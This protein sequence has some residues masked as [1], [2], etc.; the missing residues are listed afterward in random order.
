MSFLTCRVTST[1]NSDHFLAIEETITRCTYADSLP[2]I[3]LFVR[4]SK[5]FC[6]CS[7]RNNN[8]IGRDFHATISRK[9]IRFL[10]EVGFYNLTISHVH[11]KSSSLFA[12]LHHHLIAV[13][14]IRI[15]GKVVNN[16]GL[17]KLPSGLH[18]TVF[19]G[20]QVSSSGIDSRCIARRST[21][22]NQTSGM[23]HS[24]SSYIFK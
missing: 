15:T 6:R 20:L 22:D 1:Y 11:T 16:R 9:D 17:S 8:A 12:Q 23:F 7:C 2:H 24:L 21:S 14:T 10:W 3:L 18:S 5:V 19:H 4:K 13:N